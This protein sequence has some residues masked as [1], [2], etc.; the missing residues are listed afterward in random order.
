M[1][2]G[3]MRAVVARLFTEPD[4]LARFFADPADAHAAHG[5]A[6]DEF[7]ALRTLDVRT[8]GITSEG[9]AGKRF[10]RV[11]SAFPSTLLALERLDPEAKARYLAETP[12]PPNEAGERA[13]FLAHVRQGRGPTPDAQRFL[14]DL[15]DLEQLLFES[16]RPAGLPS[17]R[18]R[19]EATRPR[20]TPFAI[21]LAARGPLPKGLDALP[22]GFP[23]AYARAP[24]D[25]LVLRDGPGFALEDVTG[26]LS[27]LLAACDGTRTVEALARD[28]GPATAPAIERW[29]RYRVVDDAAGA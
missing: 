17:Y 21:L 19:P 10:E 22:S 11:A 26:P 15:A 2:L 14:E 18:Y 3:A 23:A 6:P 1:T 13:T 9:Y 20:R 29:L 25:F 24:R 7:A 8:L 28:L 5:L 27:T 12:Y 4:Y 16:P